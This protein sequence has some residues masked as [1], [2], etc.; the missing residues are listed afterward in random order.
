MGR[1]YSFPFEL[2]IAAFDDLLLIWWV[3]PV[4]YKT[5]LT[6]SKGHIFK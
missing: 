5:M 3:I 6:S 4:K 1:K 2:L